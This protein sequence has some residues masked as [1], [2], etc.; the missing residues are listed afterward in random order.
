MLVSL[1]IL[2][3]MKQGPGLGAFVSSRALASLAFQSCIHSLAG[4]EQLQTQ[5][6][7]HSNVEVVTL[8]RKPCRLPSHSRVSWPPPL[9]AR[10]LL[11]LWR[12]RPTLGSYLIKFFIPT[13]SQVR[14]EHAG[15]PEQESCRVSLAA[16]APA[17]GAASSDLP[18]TGLLSPDPHQSGLCSK[19]S[20]VPHPGLSSPTAIVSG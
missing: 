1:V 5:S 10:S 4:Q 12:E 11:P 8:Q 3:K 14:R 16:R 6:L 13:G 2:I 9:W 20:P 19:L 15:C 7:R 17:L 18:S